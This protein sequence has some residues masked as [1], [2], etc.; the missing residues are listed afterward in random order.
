VIKEIE[1]EMVADIA[2][3]KNI[4]PKDIWSGFMANCED[5]H[6][7]QIILIDG[8]TLLG[9]SRMMD[10]AVAKAVRERMAGLFNRSPDGLTMSLIMGA[11]SQA[12]LYIAENGASPEDYDK[13][14]DLIDFHSRQN[15]GTRS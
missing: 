15:P 8:P 9:R 5:P 14:R 10:G 13:I 4:D 12:A 6:F 2:G 1:S 11:L 7:R 3:R